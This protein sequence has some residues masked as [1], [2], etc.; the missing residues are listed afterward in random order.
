MSVSNGIIT[1]PVSIEDVKKVLG[2]S[3][4]DLASLCTADN[5]NKWSRMKPC[6]FNSV[7]KMVPYTETGVADNEDPNK[8]NIVLSSQTY[9]EIKYGTM[10]LIFPKMVK[11]TEIVD[12]SSTDIDTPLGGSTSVSN[13]SQYKIDPP[14]GQQLENGVK[15]YYAYRL[16]DFSGYNHNV[17]VPIG[18]SVSFDQNIFTATIKFSYDETGI[19]MPMFDYNIYR[20]VIWRVGVIAKNGNKQTLFLAAN[21][22]KDATEAEQGFLRAFT[23]KQAT[24]NISG[25]V[26]PLTEYKFTGVLIGYKVTVD[27]GS[28]DTSPITEKVSHIWATSSDNEKCGIIMPCESVTL[29]SGAEAPKVAIKSISSIDGVPA[30]G[31]KIYNGSLSYFVEIQVEYNGGTVG[32]TYSDVMLQFAPSN[33]IYGVLGMIGDVVVGADETKTINYYF[34]LD[35]PGTYTIE[36]VV[37]VDGGELEVARSKKSVTIIGIA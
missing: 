21:D 9:T 37:F 3:T 26:D 15:K 33:S 20:N 35:K 30:D 36:A 27:Y 8:E 11:W 10:G 17:G 25:I 19:T 2:K 12:G 34:G 22:K 24:F 29:T 6:R 31:D 13:D 1:A 4:N 14:T 23:S 28:G 32:K 7:V 16:A 18:M 5:I